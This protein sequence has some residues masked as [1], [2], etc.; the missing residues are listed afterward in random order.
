M[1]VSLARNQRDFAAALFDPAL[2]VPALLRAASSVRTASAF[3]VYRNNVASGLIDV[4][5]ARFPVIV[6]LIGPESFGRLALCF[7]VR[8]PPRSP[9]LLGYGDGFPEF[10]GN[11]SAAPSAKYLA[12]LARLEMARGRAYHAA[13]AVPVAAQ[14]FAG[15]APGRLPVLRLRLHPSLSLLRSEYPVVSAWETN[16]PGADQAIRCWKGEDALV[17]RPCDEVTVT[18]L[19]EGGFAFLTALANGATLGDAIEA[20][21]A[22]SAA[23]D[24]PGNLVILAGAGIVTELR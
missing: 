13:D 22:D 17:A 8:S 6:R 11:L 4:L 23:F 18:R 24:L 14:C 10:L 2:A 16:Q 9:V 15:L 12:D 19:P 7:I 3:A 20:G 21:I 1:S 5:M